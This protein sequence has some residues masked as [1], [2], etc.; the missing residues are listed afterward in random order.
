MLPLNP[1]LLI[2]TKF[3]VVF[4]CIFFWINLGYKVMMRHH[5]VRRHPYH[6]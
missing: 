3:F 5:R 6:K 4:T 2:W 1:D